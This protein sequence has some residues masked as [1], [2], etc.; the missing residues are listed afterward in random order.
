MA[1]LLGARGGTLAARF[2]YRAGQPLRPLPFD[3]AGTDAFGR[4]YTITTPLVPAFPQGALPRPSQPLFLDSGLYGRYGFQTTGLRGFRGLGLQILV[5]G[6][7]TVAEGDWP[8][9]EVWDS[10]QTANPDATGDNRGCPPGYFCQYLAPANAPTV[11]VQ[12]S[13][14]AAYGSGYLR[15]CRRADEAIIG[16]PATIKAESG[17]GAWD[18]TAINVAD[19]TRQ[20]VDA[21]KRAAGDVVPALNAVAWIVGGLAAIAVARAVRA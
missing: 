21:V 6:E 16:S 10:T 15:V 17:A 11:I 14:S 9:Y 1:T 5:D 3:A 2:Q 8:V 12:Q 20:T 18:Q 13:P 4:P 19:T 7:W